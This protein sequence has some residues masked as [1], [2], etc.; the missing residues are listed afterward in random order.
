MRITPEADPLKTLSSERAVS[1]HSAL[2]AEE[3]IT[4]ATNSSDGRPFKTLAP[5]KFGRRGG[6]GT[7]MVGRWVRS[8][9]IIDARVSPNH[10]WRHR[11]KTLR[12]DIANALVWHR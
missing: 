12:P 1:V 3:F 5:D 9:G 10:S 7:K 4:F 8:L 11:L 6:N 2:I